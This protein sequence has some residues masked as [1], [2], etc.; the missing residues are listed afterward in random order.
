MQHKPPFTQPYDTTVSLSS[1]LTQVLLNRRA[2]PHFT[3]DSVPDDF[4]EVILTFGGQAPTRYSL[5]PWRFIFVRDARID[6]DCRRRH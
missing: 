2:R 1:T 5:Q 3:A 6:G 4:L